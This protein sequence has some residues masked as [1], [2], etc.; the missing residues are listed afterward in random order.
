MNHL[1]ILVNFKYIVFT[2]ETQDK[3]QDP[4]V[5]APGITLITYIH[6]G[7]LRQNDRGGLGVQLNLKNK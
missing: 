4:S 2:F 3:R 6:V 1:Q 7:I 5:I